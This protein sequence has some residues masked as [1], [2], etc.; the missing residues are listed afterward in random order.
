MVLRTLILLL[1]MAGWL[2]G[3]QPARA[4]TIHPISHTDAWVRVT[5]RVDV[6]LNIFLDDVLRYEGLLDNAPE[7]L[8]RDS[9]ARAV[10]RYSD[11]VLRQLQIFGPDGRPL[12]AELTAA[13]TWKASADEVDL[14]ANDLLK[15]TWK[16]R[17]RPAEGTP[18]SLLSFEHQFTHP[19]LPAPG[20]LR[21][22]VQHQPT[23]RRLDAVVP[24]GRPH[25]LHLPADRSAVTGR[26]LNLMQVRMILNASHISVELMAPAGLMNAA[27][28]AESNSALTLNDR[29]DFFRFWAL[30]NVAAQINGLSVASDQVVVEFPELSPERR[31]ENVTRSTA[32]TEPDHWR[33]R[34][35]GIRLNYPRPRR[36][37]SFALAVQSW[38]VSFDDVALEKV[39]SERR[40]SSL[41]AT[42]SG[43]G[44][45]FEHEWLPELSL[46]ELTLP[47]DRPGGELSQ[48]WDLQSAEPSLWG[49][50]TAGGL[51]AVWLLLLGLRWRVLKSHMTLLVAVSGLLLITAGY[52]ATR[53]TYR[54][55]SGDVQRYLESA[56]TQIYTSL[57]GNDEQAVVEVLSAF[58]EP[59]VT[60]QTFLSAMG[61]LAADPGEPVTTV[62]GL[63]VARVDVL[64]SRSPGQLQCD[65]Q[66][67]VGV[68]IDHWGHAH[69]RQLNLS[70]TLQ[71]AEVGGRWRI[72]KFQPQMA[73]FAENQTDSADKK[74][75]PARA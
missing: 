55:A 29:Q 16:I 52:C 32:L 62:L 21:L 57:Q 39:T 67:E 7:R 47:E 74:S 41:I 53:V 18:L 27:L 22:H 28:P 51:V 2:V 10:D 37:E 34:L 58:M 5:D 49:R 33:T 64:P 25:V 71:L 19:S 13:P 14:R 72:R 75:V 46:P 70:G 3:A 20:E 42:G 61:S 66:W 23:S 63:R 30:Q 45:V 4:A 6:R 50:L 43:E 24:P 40:T 36:I 11:R 26:D 54:A 15:L 65:C 35:V 12:R 9:V 38:P 44:R 68:L 48:Q 8:P 17:Y 59:D 31:A 56:L 73:R 60:E 1:L 69:Q